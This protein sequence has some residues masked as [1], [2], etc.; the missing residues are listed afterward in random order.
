VRQSLV[1]FFQTTVVCLIN[2]PVVPVFNVAS[3]T[4]WNKRNLR[5]SFFYIDS[6]Q[7]N[8]LKRAMCILMA[9]LNHFVRIVLHQCGK[10]STEHPCGKTFIGPRC[11]SCFFGEYGPFFDH[12]TSIIST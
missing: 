2:E 12:P 5:L 4:A 7:M 8:P 6:F 9:T 3:V 11:F 10:T 1:S